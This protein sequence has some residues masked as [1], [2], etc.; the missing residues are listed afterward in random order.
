MTK[1]AVRIL[2]TWAT[3]NLCFSYELQFFNG[4]IDCW[5]KRGSKNDKF[6]FL[7]LILIHS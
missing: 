1:D 7:F 5:E 3:G 2:L 6:I 4:R